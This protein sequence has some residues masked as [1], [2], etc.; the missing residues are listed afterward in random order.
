VYKK[1]DSWVYL[2]IYPNSRDKNLHRVAVFNR[3][4]T[5]ARIYNNK[6]EVFVRGGIK[7]LTLFPSDQIFIAQVLTDKGGGYIHSCGIDF[8]GKGI[9]FAGHSGAGK[10]TMARMLKNKAKILCDDRIIIRNESKGLK[11][12][13]TWSHGDV[14]D[15]SAGSAPLKAIL[16]LKKAKNNFTLPLTDKKK[17]MQL[18]L[19]LWIKPFVTIGWWEKTLILI[20]K[21]A[22]QIPCYSLYFTKDCKIINLLNGLGIEGGAKCLKNGAGQN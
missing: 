11:I 17:I 9:L 8:H 15:I 12:Y 6:E 7:N 19:S 2:G 10:S 3:G 13:G 4:Y 14:A 16:F 20:D 5:R 21:I 1:N 18:L 22:D